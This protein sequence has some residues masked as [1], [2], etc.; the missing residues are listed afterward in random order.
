[1]TRRYAAFD[2]ETAKV[3]P[4]DVEDVLAHRPLG[5]ACAAVA[6]AD[7]PEPRT[8]VGSGP[9]GPAPRL[10]QA[11]AKD[12]V[13]VLTSLVSEG[14]ML[15]TWNGLHFDFNILAE[16]SG[17]PA[18]CARLALSHVD[19]MFHAVCGLGHFLAIQKAA[20]ALR[21]PGKTAGISGAMAPA[22]WAA[23]RHAEVLAYN[24]QDVRL[25]LAVAQ[26]CEQRRELPWV[27][28]KGTIGR[29]PLSN[30]WLS[31]E[32]ARRLPLPD[33]SW[34]SKPPTREHLFAW[35][36]PEDRA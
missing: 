29:M 33:T 32:E 36:P 17:L 26:T 24:I 1:M 9:S 16:E 11:E 20:E 23:G 10:S 3:L 7:G 34:M 21:I 4:A 28:R 8:W 6:F 35:I 5:I 15:L 14:Y 22:M 13:S 30:G 2:L 19:M 25:T 27:T 31:V 12:L 18:Q